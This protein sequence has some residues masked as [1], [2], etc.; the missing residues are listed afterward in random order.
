MNY[1]RIG[2]IMSHEIIHGF[3][4]KDYTTLFYL[5]SVY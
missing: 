2:F 4:T 1:G 3:D 5:T